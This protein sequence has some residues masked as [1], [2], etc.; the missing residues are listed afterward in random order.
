MAYR[1]NN[2]HIEKLSVFSQGQRQHGEKRKEVPG[3]NLRGQHKKGEADSGRS[4]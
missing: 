2:K 1:E 4:K 3:M